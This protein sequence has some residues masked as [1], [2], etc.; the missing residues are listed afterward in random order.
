MERF[1]IKDVIDA[2]LQYYDVHK[3]SNTIVSISKTK[4]DP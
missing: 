1:Q 2:L 3:I 4:G